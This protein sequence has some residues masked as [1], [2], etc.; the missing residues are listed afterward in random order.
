MLQSSLASTS[1]SGCPFDFG[2]AD[3]T[4]VALA[5]GFGVAK[6]KRAVV[7][8]LT[9]QVSVR[10][11]DHDS[12]VVCT[13][14]LTDHWLLRL[15]PVSRESLHAPKTASLLS[16]YLNHKVL[17]EQP[18]FVER[19]LVGRPMGAA[20]GHNGVG[21]SHPLAF[22][23]RSRISSKCWA[24]KQSQRAQTQKFSAL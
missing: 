14:L 22:H 20:S 3:D 17:F 6:R 4:L 2:A 1:I 23:V 15:L 18:G 9:I 21:L 7:D 19:S 10:I 12:S 8:E 24:L 13:C 5:A 16:R 11:D